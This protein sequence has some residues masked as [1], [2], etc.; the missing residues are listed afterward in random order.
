MFNSKFIYIFGNSPEVY[1]I[2]S[3]SDNWECNVVVG[4]PVDKFIVYLWGEGV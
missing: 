1:L 3:R 2:T 4:V